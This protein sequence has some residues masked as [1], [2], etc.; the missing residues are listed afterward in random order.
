VIRSRLSLKFIWLLAAAPV[1]L[2]TAQ[3]NVLPD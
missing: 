3:M 2:V 1:L